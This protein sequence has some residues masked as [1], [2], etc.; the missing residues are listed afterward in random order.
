MAQDFTNLTAWV[1]AHELTIKV[2]QLAKQLPPSERYNRASQTLR[3]VSSIEA[4]IA[5]G[6]GRYYFQENIAFCRKARGSLS[7][8][9][10]HLISA[11]DL[12]QLPQDQVEEI[13]QDIE[14]LR[15]ILNGYIRY[16]KNK[17]PQDSN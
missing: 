2:Y 13:L 14:N 10:C 4:N 17:K 6:H 3:A 1:K 5:E 9:Q 16:L 8:L 12:G 7:E 11:R 15:K